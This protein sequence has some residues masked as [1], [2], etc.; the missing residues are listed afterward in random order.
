MLNIKEVLTST[1]ELISV[2]CDRC[3]KEYPADSM[4][5]DEF[6]YIRYT[7]AFGDGN[8]VS[9]DLCSDCLYELIKTFC[10]YRD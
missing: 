4:G 6:H 10:R 5:R 7:S 2:I 3:K 9:C 8:V 1:N